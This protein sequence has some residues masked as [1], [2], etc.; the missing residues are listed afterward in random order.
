MNKNN[1]F[2]ET[3]AGILQL[4]N[5]K[6]SATDVKFPFKITYT[7]DREIKTTSGCGCL[8]IVVKD[9]VITGNLLQKGGQKD[10]AMKPLTVWFSDKKDYVMTETGVQVANPAISAIITIRANILPQ[11][12]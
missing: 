10:L 12:S 7:G 1:K 8:D 2:T 5:V 9:N 4:P 3:N 6:Y 11:T